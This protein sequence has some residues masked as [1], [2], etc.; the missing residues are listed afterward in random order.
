M[1]FQSEKRS[2]AKPDV[3]TPCT[4]RTNL[5]SFYQTKLLQ[6]A[7]VVL[8]R[9]GEACPLDPLQIIHLNT[10]GGP[11][12]NVA[13]RS[14]DLEHTDQAITF[15]PHDASLVANLDSADRAQ[16]LSIR[17]DFAVRFQPG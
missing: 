11:P 3:I 4:A 14:D 15:E 6:P 2:Q 5:R 7:M 10:V 12:L 8:N 13:I 17:V 16:A 9:P 1:T